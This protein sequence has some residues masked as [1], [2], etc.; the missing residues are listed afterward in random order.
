MTRLTEEEQRKLEGVPKGTWALLLAFAALL[1]A[2]WL[3][4]YFGIFLSHGPVN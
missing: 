2:G 3:I 4:M 1:A